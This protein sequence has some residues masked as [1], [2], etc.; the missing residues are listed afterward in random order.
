MSDETPTTRP[1]AVLVLCFRENEN[2]SEQILFTRRTHEVLHHKG[3][4]CFPGGAFDP[5]DGSL[6]NTALRETREEIGLDP[7]LV[8]LVRELGPWTTPTG[9]RVTPFVGRI[10]KTPLWQINEHEIAELFTV[11]LAHLQ[12]PKN[13]RWI[14]KQ[15]NGF[16]YL[17]PLFVYRHYEIWGLTARV[18]CEFLDHPFPPGSR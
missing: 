2:V 5:E 4:I 18:L 12:N 13:L 7:G 15:V 10:P 8:T 16:E 1:A 17:D 6:W 3:Q 9:F 14:K 11:P